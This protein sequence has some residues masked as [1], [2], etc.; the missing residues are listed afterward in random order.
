MNRGSTNKYELN[1]LK[2]SLCF[3]INVNWYLPGYNK[4]S[5]RFKKYVT[6]LI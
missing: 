1:I 3:I 5:K 6:K 2:F 4:I